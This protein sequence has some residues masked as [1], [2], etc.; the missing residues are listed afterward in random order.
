MAEKLFK[1]PLSW[2]IHD[3]WTELLTGTR[4]LLDFLK[5]EQKK[6][7]KRSLLRLVFVSSHQMVEVMLFIQIEK[8]V[9]DKP[10]VK[11]L[12]EY[13]LEKRISFRNALKKW[14]KILTG[15]KLNLK[16]EPLKSMILLSD[17]RNKAIHHEASISANMDKNKFYT[18]LGESAFYTAIES[19]KAIYNH[20]NQEEPWDESEYAKF[21]EQNQIEAIEAKKLLSAFQEYLS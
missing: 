1:K 2:K 4:T 3:S 16:V 12:F 17:I 7:T 10:I 9:K 18:T 19:S 15:K 20:I 13:D 14:P 5:K 21:V 6:I 11:E 8:T